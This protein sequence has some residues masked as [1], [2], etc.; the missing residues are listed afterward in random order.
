MFNY[1]KSESWFNVSVN[2]FHILHIILLNILFTFILAVHSEHI[3]SHACHHADTEVSQHQQA[4]QL[5]MRD[6]LPGFGIRLPVLAEQ[7]ASCRHQV[8]LY[9]GYDPTCFVLSFRSKKRKI[10][11]M[12]A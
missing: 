7:R 9:L 5:S 4:Q 8:C 12:Q 6:N 1:D 2:P 11:H 3:Q 10:I